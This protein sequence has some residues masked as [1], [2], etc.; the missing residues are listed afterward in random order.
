MDRFSSTLALRACFRLTPPE[1]AF[2][3]PRFLAAR[4]LMEPRKSVP[5]KA[6]FS[7]YRRKATVLSTGVPSEN[8]ISYTRTAPPCWLRGGV[9]V[10]YGDF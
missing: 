9:A 2:V 7:T 4:R 6:G 1:R 5:K 8:N 3:G 10:M